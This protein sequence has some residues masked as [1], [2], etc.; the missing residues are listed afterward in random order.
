LRTAPEIGNEKE[1]QLDPV[2]VGEKNA[3][4]CLL[5]QW[6]CDKSEAYWLLMT[7][8]STNAFKVLRMYHQR[9]KRPRTTVN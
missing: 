2:R 3:G 5:A 8:D 1:E 4:Y 7:I 6:R 9:L